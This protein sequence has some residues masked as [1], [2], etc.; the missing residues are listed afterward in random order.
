MVKILQEIYEEFKG[1]TSDL[2]KWAR[3]HATESALLFAEDVDPSLVAR[4]VDDGYAPDLTDAEV[5]K[6]GRDPF[7]IAHALVLPTERRA[8]TTEASSPRKRRANRKLPDVCSG[9]GTVSYNTFESVRN[10]NFSTNWRS[11][12]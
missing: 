2:G 9:F 11:T 7:L 4:V 8:V 6:I 12:V 10:L 5:E 3:N 1:A